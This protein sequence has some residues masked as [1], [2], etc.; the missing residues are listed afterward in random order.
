[1]SAV[2]G[3]VRGRSSGMAVAQVM[4]RPGTGDVEKPEHVRVTVHS[5]GT[6]TFSGKE[7]RDL[8]SART[9]IR[10]LEPK[11]CACPALLVVNGYHLR[12]PG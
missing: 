7:R 12:K 4:T 8:A 5:P 3:S 2:S 9:L 6:G 1:M 11:K 10:C